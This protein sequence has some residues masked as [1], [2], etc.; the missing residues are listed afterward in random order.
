M[1]SFMYMTKCWHYKHAVVALSYCA[2]NS[3]LTLTV[4]GLH[5]RRPLGS[6]LGSSALD[7]DSF[8]EHKTKFSGKMAQWV[9]AI[10]KQA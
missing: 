5:T 9:K 1:F 4:L 7:K 8:Y 10:A 2:V 3:V 6:I